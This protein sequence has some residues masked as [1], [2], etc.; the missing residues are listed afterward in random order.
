[1]TDMLSTKDIT[2]TVQFSSREQATT[3]ALQL[4]QKARREICFF[5][6]NIDAVL[7]DNQEIIESLSEFA[8]SNHR[9]SIK[10]A[11]HSSTTNIQNSHRL[12]PLAQRLTSSIHIHRT[13]PQ[14]HELKQMFLLIDDTSYLYCQKS[15]IYKGRASFAD[16]YEVRTLKKSFSEIWDHSVIDSNARRLNL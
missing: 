13:A 4:V 11:I 3:L 2:D 12:I 7:F 6:N 15:D 10:F 16:R 1:M 14:H 5:G 8:R 9:T